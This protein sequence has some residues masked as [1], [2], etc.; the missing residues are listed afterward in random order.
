MSMTMII[1]TTIITIMIIMSMT[2]TAAVAMTIII[3]TIMQMKCL[4]LG[5]KRLRES[6][7]RKRW[8]IS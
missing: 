2:N 7:R 6:I 8:S 1:M 5:E 3:T 4:L